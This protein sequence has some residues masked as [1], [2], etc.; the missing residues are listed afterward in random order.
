[1]QRGVLELVLDASRELSKHRGENFALELDIELKTQEL[2]ELIKIFSTTRVGTDEIINAVAIKM[3]QQVYGI[4]GNRGFNNTIDSD[5]NNYT[6]D[7]I[8]RASYRLNKT[9]N[10]YRKI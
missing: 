4:L 10:R 2:L 9:M 8:S 5:G 1:L 3:R 6:H 7:F